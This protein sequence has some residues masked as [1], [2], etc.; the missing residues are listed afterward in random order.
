M[1]W[2]I[3]FLLQLFNDDNVESEREDSG[4]DNELPNEKSLILN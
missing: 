2:E 1:I 4:F 3:K